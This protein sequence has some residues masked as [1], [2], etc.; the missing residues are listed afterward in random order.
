MVG[1]Q[2]HQAYEQFSAG[3][4]HRLSA[5]DLL[6]GAQVVSFSAMLNQGVLTGQPLAQ[7]QMFAYLTPEQNEI[8]QMPERLD[9]QFNPSED[10]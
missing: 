10:G 8:L 7:A 2:E 9:I 6:N 4:N 1:L 3:I 5:S